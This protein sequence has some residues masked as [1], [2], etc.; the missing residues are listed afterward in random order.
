MLSRYAALK[1]LRIVHPSC[2]ALSSQ[3]YSDP[4][5]CCTSTQQGSAPLLCCTSFQQGRAPLLCRTALLE[6]GVLPLLCSTPT[7]QDSSPPQCCPSFQQGSAPLLC[8]TELSSQSLKALVRPRVTH[9]RAISCASERREL[10]SHWGSGQRIGPRGRQTI[11]HRPGLPGSQSRT[12][13]FGAPF[14]GDFVKDQTQWS[15]VHWGVPSTINHLLRPFYGD[16]AILRLVLPP[17]RLL[18]RPAH[19]VDLLPTQR[20]LPLLLANPPHAGATR[21]R[22]PGISSSSS[23]SGS[24]LQI[25]CSVIR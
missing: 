2:A 19:P 3:H 9:L 13:S 17:V 11:R 8:G 10:R 7:Q 12:A 22:G 21:V 23:G 24:P 20:L 15:M 4:P 14:P 18:Q 5:L 6:D 16:C 25:L 1:P